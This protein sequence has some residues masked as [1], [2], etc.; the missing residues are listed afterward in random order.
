MIMSAIVLL[1][2]AIGSAF[3]LLFI[4][5][6]AVRFVT[7]GLARRLVLEG[8]F[9]KHLHAISIAQVPAAQEEDQPMATTR[10]LPVTRPLRLIGGFRRWLRENG[11]RPRPRHQ[12]RA[13]EALEIVLVEHAALDSDIRRAITR[14]MMERRPTR[15]QEPTPAPSVNSPLE[16]PPIIA[17]A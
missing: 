4:A 13:R 12:F 15:P 10:T 11:F 7:L 6:A 8:A 3:V 1:L 14:V 5:D 2:T 16:P 17:S 9:N